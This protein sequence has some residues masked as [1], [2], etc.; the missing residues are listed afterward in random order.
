MGSSRGKLIQIE[1]SKINKLSEIK[2]KFDCKLIPL[3]KEYC[4]RKDCQRYGGSEKRESLQIN[5]YLY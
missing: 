5:E 4:K 3:G 2:N 1:L